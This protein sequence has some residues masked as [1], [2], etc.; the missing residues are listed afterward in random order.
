MLFPK[1]KAVDENAYKKAL[2]QLPKPGA[3]LI[4]VP[5]FLH[6]Q[7][8]IDSIKRGFHF[9]V[10]KP[11]VTKLKDLYDIINLM[12]KQKVLGLVDYHKVYDETN[13]ILKDDYKNGRYGD[14]QH[15]FVKMT[16][17]RDMLKILVNGLQN[18]DTTLIIT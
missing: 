6:K 11:I 15:I 17:R 4:A 3:V 16:Q 10:V 5:D 9:M 13:L 14:I 12:K 8:V 1:I 7:M 2:A 18:K